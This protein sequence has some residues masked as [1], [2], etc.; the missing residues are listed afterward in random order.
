MAEL[1][2]WPA[3]VPEPLSAPPLTNAPSDGPEVIQW[4]EHNCVYGEGD[5]YGKPVKLELFEK[6]LLW[7][8][9]EKTTNGRYRY[10][11]ALIEMP[12]GNGKSLLMTVIALY[13][14]VNRFSPVIPIGAA[15]FDQAGLVFRDMQIN[16][17][18]S[19][20]LR[21]LL[22]AYESD[23]RRKDGPGR[24]YRVYATD[25]TNDGARPTTVLADEIHAW[26]S[27]KQ[28]RSHLVLTN[29]LSKRD[30]ALELNVTTPGY[31]RDSLAGRM[32]DYGLKVNSG[33]IKDSSFLHVQWG[34]EPDRFDLGTYE[35]ICAAIRA[36]SPAA[37]KFLNVESVA[38]KYYQI[39]ELEFHRYHLG[40]WTVS[41]DSWL[42][43][44]AWD[45]CTDPDKT[46]PDGGRV[47]LGFDGSFSR[48][49]TALV[50]VT[51]DDE[52]PHVDVVECWERPANAWQGWRVPTLDVVQA[53]R[54]AC[55]RYDV[56]EVVVDLFAWRHIFEE[57][58]EEGI[59]VV[60]YPQQ[61]KNMTGACERAFDV[62]REGN[63]THSGDPRLA[64]HVANARAKTGPRGRT[65]CKEAPHSPNKID[66]AVAMCMALD[67]A[68]ALR[69]Q[70]YDLLES[71]W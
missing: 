51:V 63:M 41:I 45:A 15:S 56:A 20:T 10:R 26:L 38:A 61:T 2:V 24:A 7:W 16:V 50:M 70:Q 31:H 57:L 66:L 28:E 32:H 40:V 6:L 42:P 9:F 53:I 54:D 37:D 25:G 39:D 5:F 46:I 14:L 17:E 58:A 23:I 21:G 68:A 59:N 35:G 67:R 62:I 43:S 71:V 27:P 44:G 19:P 13:L 64:R 1:V 4:I 34:C 22:I 11:R 69:P 12:K 8:L 48:D 36:A 52:L 65:L 18:E 30:Y 47:V 3:E 49:S 33:E 55:G 29:G 60:D